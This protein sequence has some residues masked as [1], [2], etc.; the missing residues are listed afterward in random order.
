MTSQSVTIRSATSTD[1]SSLVTLLD[2]LGYPMDEAALSQHLAAFVADDECRILMAEVKDQPVGMIMAY[3]A[4][5][6]TQG[7]SAVI[8]HLIVSAAQRGLGI[9]KML[10]ENII[11]WSTE[12]NLSCVKVGSQT[13][14]E[15]AHAFYQQLGFEKHKTQQW[16]IHR[17]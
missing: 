17:L 10:V 9:G 1:Y 8:G 11:Q 15:E 16:F 2:E 3:T 4:K 13:F 14:R 7:R 12:Q 6:L 5:T